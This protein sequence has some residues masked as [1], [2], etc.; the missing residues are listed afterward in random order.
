[1][2]LVQGPGTKDFQGNRYWLLAYCAA[3]LQAP[4]NKQL[5]INS[6]HS[7]ATA[8]LGLWIALS[9]QVGRQYLAI[10]LIFDLFSYHAASRYTVQVAESAPNSRHGALSC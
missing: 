5:P 2:Y 1:M 7:C 6:L 10:K 9:R 8:A 4:S 3:L